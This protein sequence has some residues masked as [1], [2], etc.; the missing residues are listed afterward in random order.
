MRNVL[1]IYGSSVGQIRKL[2]HR[3]KGYLKK[4]NVRLINVS[5]VTKLMVMKSDLILLGSSTWGS[6]DIKDDFESFSAAMDELMLKQKP[7]A[8]FG[9]GER[10]NYSEV[11]CQSVNLISERVVDY[12]GKLTG[13]GLKVDGEIELNIDKIETFVTSIQ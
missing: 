8:V 1:I 11:F 2:A 6:E 12:G 7:V 13:Y 9:S 5:Q 4:D 3:I 10:R